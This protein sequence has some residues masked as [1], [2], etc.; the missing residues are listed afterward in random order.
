[1]RNIHE[2]LFRLFHISPH[3]HVMNRITYR[4]TILICQSPDTTSLL[5]LLTRQRSRRANQK[6]TE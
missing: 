1:M 6:C 4:Y 5:T 2:V 3:C